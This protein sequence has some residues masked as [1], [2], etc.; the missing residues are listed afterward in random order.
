MAS[1]M[2]DALT[3]KGTHGIGNLNSK[4]TVHMT[5]G[6]IAS[7]AFDNFTLVEADYINGVFTCK[8]LTDATKKGYLAT[9]VEEEHLLEGE[10]YPDFY[11]GKGEM[12][13]LT[14]VAA[15]VNSRFETSS[16]VKD[17]T[18]KAIVLGQVAHF[19]VTDKVFIISN[20]TA[21]HDDYTTAYNKFI[22]V[23]NDSD[24]GYAFDTPTIRLQS[25]FEFPE[26]GDGE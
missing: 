5:N 25:I 19:D 13:R 6:A 2:T 18:A 3:V 16:F 17:A 23:D 14:D 9:T 4:W 21:V 26:T 20:D 15:Q 1:R 12:V 11:N 8:Q 24:F 22:V 10:E 7:A